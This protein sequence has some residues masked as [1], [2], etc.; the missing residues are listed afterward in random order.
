M[1]NPVGWF[2]IHVND[3]SRAKAFYQSIL[4]VSLEPLG[5]PTGS[6]TEMWAF[7][8]DF[9]KYG[10]TGALV[11]MDGFTAGGSGTIVYFSCEDCAVEESR[12][13]SAGG[14]IEQS[15]MSIGQ[16]GFC[17]LAVDTEGNTF[18]LHSEQ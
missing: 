6:D 1:S 7:G 8:S 2:E 5:D 9:E 16:Y 13:V 15:K 3:M 12:V 11:K 10:A 18:G 4:G 17:T 14:R